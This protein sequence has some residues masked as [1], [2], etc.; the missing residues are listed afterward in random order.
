MGKKRWYLLPPQYT[1]LLYDTFGQNLA[2]C[3]FDADEETFPN[4]RLA[5]AHLVQVVQNECEVLF[6]PSG[7]HH[8]VENMRDTLSINHNWFNACNLNYAMELLERERHEAA[9]AICDC[10]DLCATEEEFEAL[11]QRNVAANA[12]MNYADFSL[13]LLMVAESRANT[14][15]TKEEEGGTQAL[16]DLYE[17]KLACAALDK[18]AVHDHEL[19]ARTAKVKDRL[20]QRNV[21]LK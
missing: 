21:N 3:F 17:A 18:L 19:E 12:S 9:Q 4:L 11:V 2:P 7:W 16:L 13:L 6:V 1:H 20:C 5:R 10:R 15:E 8:T 14:L